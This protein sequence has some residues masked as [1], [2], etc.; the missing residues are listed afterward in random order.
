MLGDDAER[1]LLALAADHDRDLARGRRVQLRPARA[2]AR[3]RVGERVQA[4]ARSA[5][6]VAVLVV[7]VLEPARARA[8]DEAAG[9]VALRAHVVDRAGHVGLQI[10]VAVRVAAHERAELDALGLLGP[11][12]E[13]RPRLEVQAVAVAREREEVVPVEDDVDPEVFESKHGVADRRV[14]GVLGLDL[15]AEAHGR[16]GRHRSSLSRSGDRAQRVVRSRSAA[17]V[18]RGS[19]PPGV[20]RRKPARFPVLTQ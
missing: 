2:D 20:P 7:V 6:L 3:H 9:A 4:G 1:L 8:E 18:T 14:E 12:T 17:R 15:H 10:G 5:E 16:F 19:P 11:R 13:H